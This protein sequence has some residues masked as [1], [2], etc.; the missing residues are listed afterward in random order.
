MGRSRKE[1]V[2][3]EILAAKETV[4][5]QGSQQEFLK[6]LTPGNEREDV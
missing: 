2:T 5:G 6:V 3:L 4:N 1:Q